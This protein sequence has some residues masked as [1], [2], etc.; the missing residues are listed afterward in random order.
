VY[1]GRFRGKTDGFLE[2]SLSILIK[3]ARLN[4]R[5]FGGVSK[6]PPI[7]SSDM[8]KLNLYTD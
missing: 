2:L 1:S 6:K 4:L 8:L 5:Q 7:D 3:V